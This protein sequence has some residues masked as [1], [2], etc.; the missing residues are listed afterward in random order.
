MVQ[1][2][3][4]AVSRHRVELYP[5]VSAY[6]NWQQ[7]ATDLQLLINKTRFVVSDFLEVNATEQERN[8]GWDLGD[9][10]VR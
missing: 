9:Y 2:S 5:D 1:T 4:L 10:L 6:T 7:K 8:E 3:A